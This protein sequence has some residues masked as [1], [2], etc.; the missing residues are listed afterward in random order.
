M[1]RAAPRSGRRVRA[2][3]PATARSP[4][5]PDRDPT[6]EYRTD[7]PRLHVAAAARRVGVAPS[8]LRTWDRRYGIGPTDHTPGR[9]RRYS[10]D[11]L[12]RL[13][14]MHRALIQGATPADAAAHALDRPAGPL[15]R[16][17]TATGH[18]RTPSR[19]R[20]LHGGPPDRCRTRGAATRRLGRQRTTPGPHRRDGTAPARRRTASPRPGAGRARARRRHRPRTTRRLDRRDRGAGHLGRRDPARAG[21]RGAALGRHRRGHRDRAPAQRLRDRRVQRGGGHRR[22]RAYRAAGTAR[23][24]GGR[25]A[26]PSPGRARHD[27]RAAGRVLPVAGR[28]TCLRQHWRRRSGAPHRPRCCCGPS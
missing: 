2:G 23:R 7:G 14:L 26:P 16:R 4:T 15:R 17:T 1:R 22:T 8:T 12:A 28:P 5:H 27:T 20:N 18:H 19:H 21:R 6:T 10:P 13:D 9:H 25:S 11:D 3:A 24:D